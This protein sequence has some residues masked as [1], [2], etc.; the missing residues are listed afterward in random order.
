MQETA[1]ITNNCMRLLIRDTTQSEKNEK[2]RQ[3]NIVA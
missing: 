2:P 3:K 1:Q